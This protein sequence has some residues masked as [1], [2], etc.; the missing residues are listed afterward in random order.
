[1]A[2]TRRQF[3]KRTSLATAGAF[4]GPSLFGSPFVRQAMAQTIGDRYLVVFF[5]DGGNDGFNTV[6]PYESGTL[7]TGYTNNRKTGGGG[8]RLTQADLTGTTL[9]TGGTLIGDDPNPNTA[10]QLALHPG[11]RGLQ[12]ISA[13]AGGLKALY[14]AG[15]LAVVQGCGY[16]SY[17]LSHEESRLIWQ[18][19][20]PFGL[21]AYTG[22]GWVG[23]HLQDEYD[24]SMIP[25]VNIQSSVA[26]EFRQSTTSVLAINRLRNFGF[27][28]DYDYE[29]DASAKETAFSALYGAAQSG[30]L[31]YVGNSGVATLTSTNSYPPL[32]GLYESARSAY[33]DLYDEVDRSAARDLREIA[34]IIYG[35]HTGQSGVTARF[36]QLSNGGY[37]THSDQGA[38]DPDGQHFQLHGEVASGLKV[39][40]DDLSTMLDINGVSAWDK[41]C[42][43]VYSEFSRRIPQNDNGTDHGSQGPV[44]VLGGKVNGGVYGNHPN[45]NDLDGDENTRY[46]Q[47]AYGGY[48]ST[49]FRDVYGTMLKHWVNMQSA[50][51]A[52]LLPIDTGSASTRWTVANFD[53]KRPLGNVDLFQ[54]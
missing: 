1:M 7:R 21:G 12:A 4:F 19:A 41:T 10:T 25:G 37:D 54:P 48:R 22:T 26:P 16:P 17:S 39:F 38:V 31:S 14:D 5:L 2:I 45:V 18:T 46:R 47:D 35:V 13:G 28:Y 42:V 52:A 9:G 40:R 49:D 36:F 6:V 32:H 50:D 24:G 44:F 11:F 8:L 20:N 15:E 43:L 3:I 53:L 23:R 34:K 27:P 29:S 51:V 33:S 30:P